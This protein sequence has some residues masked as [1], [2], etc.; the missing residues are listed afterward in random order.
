MRA[1]IGPQVRA[2]ENELLAPNA[3]FNL[4]HYTSD[5]YLMSEM[6]HPH[7]FGVCWALLKKG[8]H[9]LITDAEDKIVQVRVD[10]VERQTLKVELSVIVELTAK[11]II[12]QQLNASPGAPKLAH[13]WRAKRG[14]S[15]SIVNEDGKVLAV[16]F[17]SKQD[18]E[19][20]IGLMYQ[21]GKFV[22]PKGHEPT[23]QTVSNPGMVY[24]DSGATLHELYKDVGG[25]S[26]D[27]PS[28]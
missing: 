16:N 2:K 11:P 7:F 18:A 24:L 20:H 26:G 28:G 15:H 17:D 13:R 25:Q 5:V 6:L 3:G 4:Y 22:A 1:D 10:S 14:G 23:P 19:N 27:G 9:V 12:A 21:I 8:D